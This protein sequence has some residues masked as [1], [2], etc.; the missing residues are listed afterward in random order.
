[1]STHLA[2]VVCDNPQKSD[3]YISSFFGGVDRGQCIQLT[4]ASGK[5]GYVQLT[6]ENVDELLGVI[7]EW[8][9]SERRKAK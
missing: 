7:L 9:N 8:R 6:K 5:S 3:L 2:T 4:L 1:M